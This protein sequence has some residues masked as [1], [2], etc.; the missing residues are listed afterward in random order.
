M[1]ETGLGDTRW[2]KDFSLLG[3]KVDRRGYVGEGPEQPFRRLRR[4]E[5]IQS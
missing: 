1:S 2:G 4:T 3:T 5:L